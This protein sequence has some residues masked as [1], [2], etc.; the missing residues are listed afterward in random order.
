[1]RLCLLN[2][3]SFPTVADI[4]GAI[5]ELAFD[6]QTEPKPR[7]EA[8]RSRKV[9]PVAKKVF[10]AIRQGKGEDL[11]NSFDRSHVT[12]YAKAVFTEISDETISRNY[13][14][15]AFAYEM[16]ERC[17]GCMWNSGQCDTSGYFVVPVMC[18]NGWV[19]VEYRRCKKGETA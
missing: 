5:R 14:E 7:L 8:P 4:K 16:S 13:N 12:G 10:D 18:S 19:K 9:S 15:L 2:C 17:R 1:M 11:F 3:K 6:R